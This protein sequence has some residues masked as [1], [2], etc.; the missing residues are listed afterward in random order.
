MSIKVLIVDDDPVISA[1]YG[2]HF[3]A[4]RYDVHVA[5]G[6]ISAFSAMPIFQPDVIL[7]DLKMPLRSGLDWLAT[8]RKVD[9][10]RNIPVVV[11][12]AEPPG[13]PLVKQAQGAMVSSVLFKA[14]WDPGAIVAAVA[15]A[16]RKRIE[17]SKAA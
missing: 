13:S 15:W 8:V 11:V 4:A 9:Q 10:F 16:A 2:K 14:E 1:I 6:A 5:H 7:L 3:R 17:T 12:T